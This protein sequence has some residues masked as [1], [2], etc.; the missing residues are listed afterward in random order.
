MFL[1]YVCKWEI[2][3]SITFG[4]DKHKRYIFGK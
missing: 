4:Y 3:I 1:E 2:E